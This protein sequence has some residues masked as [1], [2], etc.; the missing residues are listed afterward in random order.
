[1][2]SSHPTSTF[3]RPRAFNKV[4][5]AMKDAHMSFE[6]FLNVWLHSPD[7]FPEHCRYQSQAD[8]RRVFR[9]WLSQEP[10]V[11]RDGKA[12]IPSLQRELDSLTEMD[13]FGR[14]DPANTPPDS[15]DLD[16]VL[17]ET[18]LIPSKAPTLHAI[19]TGLLQQARAHQP[20][21]A[22]SEASA[23]ESKQTTSRLYL[24]LA[25]ICHSRHPMS[26]NF[27]PSLMD[28]YLH[29]SGVKR[30]VVELL[31]GLGVCHRY[32]S[33]NRLL[34]EIAILAKAKIREMKNDPRLVVVYDNINFKD[35][36]RDEHMG[37]RATMEALTTS[38]LTLCDDI[39][40]DT[41]LLQSMHDPC[42]YQL[43][44]EDIFD[45]PSMTGQNDLSYIMIGP[46]RIANIL[47]A[48]TM[49]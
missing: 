12:I 40:L 47:Q 5:K 29:G 7:D 8:R 46:R 36:V 4:L 19:L 10:G 37:H 33:G 41:G 11:L 38:C 49:G 9:N 27:L 16:A 22:S 25:V 48:L 39:P 18:S 24:I 20:S 23:Q 15:V 1:M 31:S 6:S 45:S 3:G 43:S 13:Q 34:N 26:S 44:L 30:R 17:S 35:T 21:Y 2:S 32:T 14:Y 28:T 42:R